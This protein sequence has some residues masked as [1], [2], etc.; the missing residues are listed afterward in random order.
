[1]C[2]PFDNRNS[3]PSRSAVPLAASPWETSD[4]ISSA[5]TKRLLS[6]AHAP[7]GAARVTANIT[8][9]RSFTN[10]A[11]GLPNR[12]KL[13]MFQTIEEGPGRIARSV[14]GR[15]KDRSVGTLDQ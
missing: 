4:T 14:F 10:N 6:A 5:L 13:R 11:V 9:K 2:H 12:Q 3:R 8:A 15:A 7:L 1:M